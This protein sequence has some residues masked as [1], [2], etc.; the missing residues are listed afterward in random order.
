VREALTQCGL[1]IRRLVTDDGDARR[2]DA[3]A[4][5][6][7]RQKRPVAILPVAADE[8][9]ARRDDRNS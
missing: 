3:E 1:E 4:K 2:V 9:G 5:Q 7:R 8:L 6:R